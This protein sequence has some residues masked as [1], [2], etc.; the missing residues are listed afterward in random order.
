MLLRDSE[1]INHPISRPASGDLRP[2]RP[3]RI[4]NVAR[5]RLRFCSPGSTKS[6]LNLNT[7]LGQFNFPESLSHGTG[8]AMSRAECKPLAQTYDFAALSERVL[9][10]AGV[11]DASLRTEGPFAYRNLDECLGLLGGYVEEIERFAVVAYMGHL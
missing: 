6:H 9:I 1:K 3:R 2:I 7:I 11:R 8:R 10:P 5:L 4:L